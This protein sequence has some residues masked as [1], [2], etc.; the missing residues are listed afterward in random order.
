MLQSRS[1]GAV[2]ERQTTGRLSGSALVNA[3]KIAVVGDLLLRAPGVLGLNGAILFLL[4]GAIAID[5]ARQR[6]QGIS[7]EAIGLIGAAMVFASALAWRDAEML[8][9]MNVFLILGL[10]TLSAFRAGRAWILRSAVGQMFKAFVLAGLN[11]AFGA[12]RLAADIDWQDKLADRRPMVGRLSAVGRGLLIATPIVLVFGALLMEAD[13]VFASLIKQNLRLDVGSALQHAIVIAVLTWIF[14]GWLRGLLF[15]TPEL[16]RTLTVRRWPQL[17]ITEISVVLGL[18]NLLFWTFSLI[19]VKYLFG[20]AWTVAVTPGLTYAEYARKGFSE[21]V[22][23]SALVLPLLLACDRLLARRRFA[24]KWIFRGLA[25]TLIVGLLAIMAS[26]VYRMRLY[27]AAFGM[28]ELRFYTVAFMGW[29]AIVQLWFT[30][31]VLTG[32]RRRFAIGALSAGLAI[33]AGLNVVNPDLRVVRTNLDRIQRGESFDAAYN[34]SLSADAAPD[35]VKA[36][37]RMVFTDQ[38]I[39]S[40]RLVKKWGSAAQSDWRNWSWSQWRARAAVQAREPAL[41]AVLNACPALLTR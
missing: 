22:T 18:L 38:C 29:L 5:L 9:V 20:G 36:V 26:A 10:L 37:P 34:S 1:G 33:A 15:G 28:T 14:G 17:G 13:A 12:A 3:I 19:Q 24:D 27:Q 4:A 16:D 2:A 8:K 21:L 31:T 7:R 32:R 6:E 35:L 40:A 41:Q 11:A 23:V 25:V 30:A 39:A